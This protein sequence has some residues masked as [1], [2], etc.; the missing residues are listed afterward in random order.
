MD[1]ETLISERRSVRHYSGE[2]LPA[3]MPERLIAAARLAPSSRNL[4]PVEFI[5]VRDSEMLRRLSRVK[6]AG[7]GMLKDAAAAI[8]VLGD[9][10][11]SDAWIE[12]CSIAM[13]YMQ[14]LASELGVGS[15]WVQCRGRQSQQKR[16]EPIGLEADCSPSETEAQVALRIAA[17]RDDDAYMTSEDYARALL[18]FPERLALEAIL[19]LGVPA[20]GAPGGKRA[21]AAGSVSFETYH[22][23]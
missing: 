23:D 6:T 21:R 16:G 17:A 10:E 8:V 22:A 3:G 14:L 5:V 1:F 19:S 7:S 4:F 15:C 11:K 12:D 13:I 18:Q 2:A 9:R 20:P